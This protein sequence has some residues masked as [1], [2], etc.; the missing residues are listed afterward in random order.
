MMSLPHGNS[1]FPRGNHVHHVTRPPDPPPFP[2][3][4]QSGGLM[5]KIWVLP[6]PWSSRLSRLERMPFKSDR[7]SI[8]HSSNDA[9]PL[10]TYMLISASW[11]LLLPVRLP[12]NNNRT[13]ESRK[14]KPR[15]PNKLSHLLSQLSAFL[16]MKKGHET[17]HGYL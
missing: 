1:P 9:L 7:D 4:S 17:M 11:P 13:L 3:G 5:S 15:G 8:I 2:G 10:A 14:P 6:A 12:S 16:N